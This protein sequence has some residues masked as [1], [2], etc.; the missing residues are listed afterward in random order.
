[1]EA[2]NPVVSNPVSVS[3]AVENITVSPTPTPQTTESF[4]LTSVQY[5]GFGS[6]FLAGLIDVVILSVVGFVVGFVIGFI[7][8][9]AG[10][11][12]NTSLMSTVR[13]IMN[14][15]S[16]A[17]SF[18]YYIYFIS[19][20]GQTP[21]KMIMKIK[22]VKASDSSVPGFLSAFLREIVGKFLSSIVILLGYFWMLWDP[23]KQ[24][25]HDKIA[26]TIVV[27]V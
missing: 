19:A 23:K 4:A 15:F 3:P 8:G 13:S 7:L 1:M 18:F 26:G 9:L 6:R 5:A 14:M 17:I 27:K 24:T 11:S 12:S 20:K 21:G 22:V 16:Y 10:M 2:N 25:W